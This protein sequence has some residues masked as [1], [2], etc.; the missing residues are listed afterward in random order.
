MPL[1]GPPR[2]ELRSQL[3]L[4]LSAKI[5]RI[6]QQLDVFREESPLRQAVWEQQLRDQPEP[7]QDSL[8]A[9][10]IMHFPLDQSAGTTDAVTRRQGG[11]DLGS[12]NREW[13]SGVVGQALRIDGDAFDCGDTF[14][15][16]WD[17]AFSC[18][19]W[20]L[21]EG[22]LPMALCEVDP[23]GDTRLQLALRDG[24]VGA[25][26]IHGPSSTHK[27][28]NSR[29]P[30]SKNRWHHVLVTY[31]G[32]S[33]AAV[34]NVFVDGLK[35]PVNAGLGSSERA[36]FPDR[37]VGAID[38]IR[39]YDRVLTANEAR[40]LYQA[41]LRTL[42]DVSAEARTPEQQESLAEYH[43]A[44]D[45]RLHQLENDLQHARDTL[46]NSKWLATRR[47]F[48]N[49]L[50]MTLLRIPHGRFTRK[51][52]ETV[53]LTRGFFLSDRE[54]S[55]RLFQRYVDDVETRKEWSGVDREI[56]RSSEHP[57]QQ[58]SWYEAVMF[59]NWLSRREGRDACYERTGR[60]EKIPYSPED[61]YDQWRLLE[62]ANGYRLPTEA[63]W[64]HAC[65]AGTQTD[66]SCGD[67]V[68]LERY[69]VFGGSRSEAIGSRL[70]NSWG[71]FDMHGNVWEL[72]HDGYASYSKGESVINPVGSPQGFYRVRR[73]GSWN[74]AAYV[75]ASSYRGMIVPAASLNDL[76]FRVALG[77]LR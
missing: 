42:A 13:E 44:E 58:V 77:P 52:G 35:T 48:V 75:C 69:A 21:S 36:V 11:G 40:T 16:N 27:V 38:D 25:S 28:A 50:G 51:E 76:G 10:L 5:D 54:V 46:A 8:S 67:E 61:H 15:P 70:C 71:L 65:R 59:C 45:K 74:D 31:D 41:G 3:L 39:A 33:K 53:T 1:G 72:C 60:R 26:L 7:P 32:S 55:V 56:S 2:D 12:E 24:H 68:F 18:G 29:V 30:V 20:F 14:R 43:R 17:G 4:R 19:C 22:V 9:A 49:S 47:W 6:Q 34:W 62:G 37:F 73:G 57:V 66:F 63:E 64:E 23:G